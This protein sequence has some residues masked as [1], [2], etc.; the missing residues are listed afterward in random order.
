MY[1]MTF[2]PSVFAVLNCCRLFRDL[3]RL[4]RSRD[5]LD[6]ADLDIVATQYW[7]AKSHILLILCYLTG[8]IHE[9]LGDRCHAEIKNVSRCLFFCSLRKEVNQVTQMSLW[10][11]WLQSHMESICV[12]FFLLLFVRMSILITSLYVLYFTKGSEI[13]CMALIH[14]NKSPYCEHALFTLM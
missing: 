6:D 1:Q 10:S 5:L 3:F 2:P 11:V 14:T 13:I 4:S 9:R 12:P 7:P 8:A